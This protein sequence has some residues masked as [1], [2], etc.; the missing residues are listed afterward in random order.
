MRSEHHSCSLRSIHF[1]P[2][3]Y[4]SSSTSTSLF[5][6]SLSSSLFSWSFSYSSSSSLSSFSSFSSFFSSY[7]TVMSS[8]LINITDNINSQLYPPIPNPYQC[9]TINDRNYLNTSYCNENL[10]SY[11]NFELIVFLN[12]FSNIYIHFICL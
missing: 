12:I 4:S 9:P 6:S 10:N 1:Q 2:I 11:L 8:S 3:M 5:L 7:Q